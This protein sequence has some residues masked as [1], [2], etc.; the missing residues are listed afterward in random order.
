MIDINK[1]KK[2]Y[3]E[4]IS[5]YNPENPR[6]V[7]KVSHI[8]RTAQK[9]KWLA[10]KLE[11][12]K[13]DVLLAELIGLLH[14]IGRFEQVRLY[15]TF[16]DRDSINHGELGVKILF[17]DNLIRKFIED[18]SY[19]EIIKKA[20]LNHNRNEIQDVIDERELLHCR[21]IR[22][23][24]KLDITHVLLNDDLEALYEFSKYTKEHITPEIKQQFISNHKINYSQRK[25]SAD[26]LVSHIAHIFDINYIF[27]L[28]EIKNTDYI[29]KLINRYDAKEKDTI[30]DLQQIKDITYKYINEKI[31]EGNICLKNY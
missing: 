22:D 6:I 2:Y 12:S 8:Y 20:I 17:E 7:L 9:A 16:V 26:I 4:Y 24:D 29:N 10:N 30:Q 11:L 13:E 15:N 14:D 5:G 28:I 31:E 18:N 3:K 1:A 21:I 23:A 19:D 25:T 27:G